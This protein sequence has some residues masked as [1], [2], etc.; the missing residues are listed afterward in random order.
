MIKTQIKVFRSFI[1]SFLEWLTTRFL[2]WLA[3][4]LLR[5]AA[6]ADAGWLELLKLRA[7]L[8]IFG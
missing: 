8:R 7:Q 3:A 1:F 2:H 6:V 4:V 5:N